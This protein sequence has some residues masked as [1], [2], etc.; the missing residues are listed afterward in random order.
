[1]PDAVWGYDEWDTFC[2]LWKH[3]AEYRN[4]F[5]CRICKEWWSDAPKMLYCFGQHGTCGICN[6]RRAAC[7]CL[8]T[9]LV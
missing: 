5:R 2:D 7:K 8:R 1:M 3:L 6:G 4:G 9:E